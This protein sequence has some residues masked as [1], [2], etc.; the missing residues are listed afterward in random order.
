MINIIKLYMQLG[1]AICKGRSSRTRL[2]NLGG[3]NPPRVLE[4]ISSKHCTKYTNGWYDT[5]ICYNKLIKVYF[6]NYMWFLGRVGIQ[7]TQGIY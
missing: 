5:L 2:V 6:Q 1:Y 7:E 4:Q 3:G